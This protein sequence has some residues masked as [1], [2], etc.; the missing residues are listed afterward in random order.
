MDITSF[1]LGMK[2]G[3]DSGGGGETADYNLRVASAVLSRDASYLGDSTTLELAEF[4]LHDGNILGSI[5]SYVYA[6]FAQVKSIKCNNVVFINGY[7]FAGDQNLELIDITSNE[8]WNGVVFQEHSLEGIAWRSD[9]SGWH[10][11]LKTIICRHAEGSSLSS[12]AFHAGS[13]PD[14]PEGFEKPYVYVPAS[15]YDTVVSYWVANGDIPLS[16][17]RK[18]EDYPEIDRWNEKFTVRYFDGD[19][20]LRTEIVKY[21]ASASY[22][23]QKEGYKF[24]GWDKDVSKV[25]EDMD[26]YATWIPASIADA[27]WS[28]IAA[29]AEAG[30]LSKAYSIGD[31]KDIT[32]T[33]ADGTTETVTMVLEGFNTDILY[34]G[35]DWSVDTTKKTNATFLAKNALKQKRKMR[36]S[37]SGIY[38]G[39]SLNQWLNGE[40]YSG[41]DSDLQSVIKEKQLAFFGGS[42]CWVPT[43][44]E[45]GGAARSGYDEYYSTAYSRYTSNAKRIKKLGND[46]EATA[47]YTSTFNT[48]G[49]QGQN[50]IYCT[51]TG[52]IDGTTYP[53]S[54]LGV[55][56][57][58]CI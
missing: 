15:D 29:A 17:L 42:K 34:G 38:S 47:Y 18:L 48:T 54:Q 39:T 44:K 25:T 10:F 43:R 2:L 4:K 5:P 7:P 32:V 28:E 22:T 1:V 50:Y 14:V 41:L 9:A 52:N 40:F 56:V 3:K 26:V 13:L 37:G 53:T 24:I 49:T 16:H 21:G 55:V 57:G 31:E 58:F 11:P 51:D 19:T 46:G 20:L 8:F 23:P 27:S 33:Y 30:T 35:S 36:N 45:L 6:G 12:V